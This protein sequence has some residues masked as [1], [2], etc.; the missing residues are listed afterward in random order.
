MQQL[1][2]QET[3]LTMKQKSQVMKLLNE[4]FSTLH[5]YNTFPAIYHP[6][7]YQTN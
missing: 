3:K 7:V 4:I 2:V 1:S 5:L 6:K